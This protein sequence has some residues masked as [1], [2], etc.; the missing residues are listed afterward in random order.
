MSETRI[1]RRPHES[2]GPLS[3]AEKLTLFV[4]ALHK[5]E[6]PR[7]L[8]GLAGP[9]RRRALHFAQTI[10]SWD[11]AKRHAR[12]TCEFGVKHDAVKRITA[13][14]VSASPSF[15][16]ALVA[17]LPPSF[18]AQFPQFQNDEKLFPVAVRAVAARQ[19]R[20]ALR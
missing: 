4:C 16:G 3:A 19:V 13:L 10:A 14:V 12:L 1:V 9:R 18:R 2:T 7:L 17:A 20:E 11:S 6:A 5:S 15:R 8:E